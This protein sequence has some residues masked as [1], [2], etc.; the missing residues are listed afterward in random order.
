MKL[1][2]APD[3]FKGSLS[4]GEICRILTHA[5]KQV[6]PEVETVSV[7]VADGGEGT[8]DALLT[9]V[10]GQR[11]VA[12]VTGPVMT[13]VEAAWGI[14]QNGIAVIEMAQTS[15][16]AMVAKEK[17]D[18][19]FTTSFGLGE[20]IAEALK[21]G[22][23]HLV[24]GIGGSA[25]NDG[26]MGLLTALGA[27]F[28]DS[29]GNV[30]PPIGA[31][32]ERV[33][34]ADFTNLLPALQEAKLTVLC[35]VTNPLLGENGA[36]YIYGPQKGASSEMCRELEAGMK[37]YAEVISKA[38]GKDISAFPGAG[39]A[40]GIGAALGGVLGADICRGIDTVLELA[41]FDRKL[42]GAALV[43]TGEGRI[44]SQSVQYGK[45]P[46]GVARRC[47]AHSVPIAA[48]VGGIGSGAEGFY[49]LC[50]SVILS[51]APGPIALEQAI[52]NA[53]AL[54]EAAA[55]RLFRAIRIGMN[56]AAQE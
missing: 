6:F 16:L 54:Y 24:I 44:D 21:Q 43:I 52:D 51:T 5:A 38:V 56:I 30:L 50:E 53:C 12:S 49:D 20:L 22:I 47:A 34:S 55:D 40:G 42:D 13:P 36:T 23:K 11:L 45:V 19:R 32:L 28:T 35:D 37:H 8:V 18:P 1:V 48:I 46:V 7:P 14:L 39:A 15:G 33:A 10:S 2:F 17:R 31:S 4:A 25:T 27:V 26:G 3:S 41:D 9:A 29:T